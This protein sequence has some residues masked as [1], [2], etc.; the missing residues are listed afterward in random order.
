MKILVDMNLSPAWITVLRDAGHE[1]IHWSTIGQSEA[2]D[3]KI[4]AWAHDPTDMWFSHMILILA[5]F[6][7][8][9]KPGTRVFCKSALRM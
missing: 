8:L 5:L 7:P 2:P 1:A 6:W 3:K 9:P 4:L